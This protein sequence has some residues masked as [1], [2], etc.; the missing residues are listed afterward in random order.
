MKIKYLF[1]FVFIP[2]F[3]FCQEISWS[4]FGAAGYRNIN[5]QR[6]IEYNQEMYFSAKIQA[7]IR[8]NKDIEAQI[9]VRGNSQDQQLELREVSVKFE[10][11][12]HMK[13]SV[14]HLKKPFTAE[15]I[16]NSESLIQIERSYVSSRLGQAGYGGRSVGIRAYYNSSGKKN[17]LPYSY[18]LFLFKNNNL[19]QGFTARYQ[20]H[21]DDD[22][23]AGASY[24]IL[25]SGG[26]FPIV[27]NAVSAGLYYYK[28]DFTG[29]LELVA[30]QDPVE[31][32][33]RKAIKEERDVILGGARGLVA[34]GFDTGADVIKKIEPL[35]LLSYFQP[36]MRYT[37]QHTFQV[38]AGSNFYFHKNVRARLNA[39]FLFTRNRFFDEY[40]LYGSMVTL[41]LQVRF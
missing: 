20:H 25:H 38:V 27:T 14:G 30:G 23:S 26:D 8:I 4:G 29:E 13:I 35:L 5:R 12:K 22:L 34:L 41:E 11:M 31:G 18:N 40:S 24:F 1:F 32:I 3:V 16:R 10:Y 17:D 2:S 19:Q 36:E 33:R 39:D 9:D 28:K 21:F 15:Q 7:D 6:I 37:K